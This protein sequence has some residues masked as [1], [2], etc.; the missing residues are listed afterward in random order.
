MTALVSYNVLVLK[1]QVMASEGP[2][3][4]FEEDQ[5]TS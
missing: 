2:P 1:C 4:V 3:R 5:W